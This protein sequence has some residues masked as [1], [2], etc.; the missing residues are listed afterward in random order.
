[1]FDFLSCM[2]CVAMNASAAS[3][4]TERSGIAADLAGPM[5]DSP[6]L[7]V[8]EERASRAATP[9]RWNLF[10]D[11]DVDRRPTSS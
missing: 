2:V 10:R 3:A 1:M 6:W 4:L 9:K 5:I 7:E 11:L 8:F